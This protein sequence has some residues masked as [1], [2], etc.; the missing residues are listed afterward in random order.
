MKD[1]SPRDLV[2]GALLIALVVVVAVSVDS[3]R[4]AFENEA[5]VLDA[6]SA[7]APADEENCDV[8]YGLNSDARGRHVWGDRVYG[9]TWGLAHD[10]DSIELAVIEC[11]V[12][13]H[14]FDGPDWDRSG[15]VFDFNLQYPLKS[16]K[17]A[18]AINEQ[19]RSGVADV[20]SDYVAEAQSRHIDLSGVPNSST[21]REG[22]VDIWGF[23][24]LMNEGIYSVYMGA[25]AARQPDRN[26]NLGHMRV[27]NYDLATGEQFFL[28]DLLKPGEDAYRA[29]IRLAAENHNFHYLDGEARGVHVRNCCVVDVD[30]YTSSEAYEPVLLREQHFTLTADALVLDCTNYCTDGLSYFADGYGP[31]LVSG[32]MRLNPPIEIPYERLATHLDPNGPYRHILNN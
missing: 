4:S 26:T 19:V 21:G 31:G 6:I 11:A 25:I 5:V 24:P 8:S 1:F 27:W 14:D 9:V 7:I 15:R 16:G 29:V 22:Y 20:V 17:H 28:S 10:D 30:E 18:E 32:L 13:S 12:F 2:A 3:D 23:V